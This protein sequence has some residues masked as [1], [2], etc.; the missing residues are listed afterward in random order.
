MVYS[1]L[2]KNTRRKIIMTATIEVVKTTDVQPAKKFYPNYRV[3]LHNDDG[4]SA[5]FVVTVLM[6]HIPNMPEPKATSIMLEA[7]RTG[8]GLVIVCC[9][10]RAEAYQDILQSEGLTITIE[11][12]EVS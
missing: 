4:I 2:S 1:L 11:P 5:P 12:V 8:I 3:L 6:K 7:H 9:Q 10:E